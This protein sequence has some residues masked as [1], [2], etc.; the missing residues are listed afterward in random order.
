MFNKIVND[1]VIFYAQGAKNYNMALIRRGQE[2]VHTYIFPMY[3]KLKATVIVAK[4]IF[5]EWLESGLGEMK[6][7]Y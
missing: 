5:M 6:M 4:E 3:I 7:S 1:Y 2:Y